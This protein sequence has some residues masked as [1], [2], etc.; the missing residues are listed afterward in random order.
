VRVAFSLVGENRLDR[1]TDQMLN[2]TFAIRKYG[3]SLADAPVLVGVIDGVKRG[4]RRSLEAQGATV[5]PVPVVNPEYRYANKL[6]MLE[7]PP[8]HEVELIV[9]LDVDILVLGDIA[10]FLKPDVVQ[11][12]TAG[13]DRWPEELWIQLFER[14]G[15]PVPAER[16][17]LLTGQRSF[18]YANTGVLGIPWRY[19]EQIRECWER[20]IDRLWEVGD[21]L[22]RKFLADQYA[23]VF[24]L[25]E[26]GLPLDRKS[27][28]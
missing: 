4:I 26:T 14:F 21:L 19:R 6:R 16:H 5:R 27:V 2:A 15:L 7:L 17:V 28:V 25:Y 20:Y 24:A 22:P 11:A 23:L 18:R 10:P 3:G 9:C 8:E 1:W 13:V 12:R